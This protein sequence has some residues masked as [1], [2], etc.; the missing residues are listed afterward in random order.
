MFD[1]RLQGAFLVA[2]RLQGADLRLAR[3]NE[4]NLEGADLED[5]LLFSADL[6]DA[7]LRGA[8][9]VDIEALKRQARSLEGATMPNG[10]KYEDWLKSKDREE[11]G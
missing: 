9:G 8:T 4:A 2:A 5:A 10:Q 1:T 7:N 3:L 6:T 11:D